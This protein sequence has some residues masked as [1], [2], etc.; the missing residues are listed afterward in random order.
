MGRAAL[1]EDGHTPTADRT[2]GA[3][4]ERA[5]GPAGHDLAAGTGLVGEVPPGARL[6]VEDVGKVWGSGAREVVALK[7]V[8]FQVRP[9][10]FLCVIGPSGCGKSTILHIIA[11]LRPASMGRVLYQG[12][13][14]H[15]PHADIGMVFQSPS[16][17]PWKTVEKNVEFGM[18]NLGVP[19]PERKER[20]EELLDLV[21]LVEFGQAYPRELSGGMAQRVAVARALATRPELLL[22]DEPFGALDAQTRE[23]LQIELVRIW[24]ERSSSVVFV[25]HSVQEAVYL[26]DRVLVVTQRPGRVSEI[27]DVPLPRPRDVTSE[28][29]RIVMKAAYRALSDVRSG[30]SG[31]GETEPG[32]R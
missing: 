6:I 30:A 27:I 15:G 18:K 5:A 17:F 2:P 4:R 29:F 22:M 16:L 26:A 28:E 19:R 10:E 31:S 13:E 24:S 9:D 23:D 20:V 32:Q 7:D 1:Q 3:G 12:R 21:G 25:T 8:N 11:G 14:V